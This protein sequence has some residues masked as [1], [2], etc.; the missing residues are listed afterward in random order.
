MELSYKGATGNMQAK[1]MSQHGITAAE[2]RAEMRKFS[3]GMDMGLT[4]LENR[5]GGDDLQT[6]WM[7][8]ASSGFFKM[9]LLEDWTKFVQ[10]KF[11]YER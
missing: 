6:K 2:A 10:D 11:V 5:L 3:L 4:Q 7:Q 9:T 1:L 8:K